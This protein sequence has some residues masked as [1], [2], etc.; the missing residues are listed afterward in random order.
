MKLSIALTMLACL[1][2]IPQE[3]E[4]AEDGFR[5]Q[6]DQATMQIHLLSNP[7]VMKELEL[8]D[9]QRGKMHMAR[10]K[11]QMLIHRYQQDGAREEDPELQQML[12]KRLLRDIDN[13]QQEFK[14]DVL[15]PHQAELLTEIGNRRILQHHIA[16]GFTRTKGTSL[17]KLGLTDLQK[18][19]LQDA[20]DE[21]HSE[22][23]AER[24]RHTKRVREIR[25]QAISSVR[26]SLTDEQREML[27]IEE[28]R[29]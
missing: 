23:E 1:A 24:E 9:E 6:I 25:E 17:E 26:N 5:N 16:T 27:N 18:Q 13:G 19:K 8:S 22:L 21:L 4:S 7:E 14:A 29:E 11:M 20:R 2:F 12:Q 28:K 15:L 3:Q 10:H